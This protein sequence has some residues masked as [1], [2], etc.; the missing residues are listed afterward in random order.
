MN[1]TSNRGNIGLAGL[2]ML[3][4]QA[5]QFDPAYYVTEAM[6]SMDPVP[7]AWVNG[8]LLLPPTFAW[9]SRIANPPPNVPFPAYFNINETQDLA[10]SLTKVVGRHTFKTGYYN[11]YS[12]KANQAA[13]GTTFSSFGA[14]S[15]AQDT[16]GTNPCDT[17]FG[18]AN[19]LT[20]CFNSFAQASKYVV[21]NLVYHN[22]EAYIQDNWKVNQ[23]L[24]L[25]YGVRFVHQTPQYDRLGQGSNFLPDR[26]SASDAPALYEPVCVV[27][28]PAGSACP[29]ASLQARNPR[30]GAVLGPGS[31]I[32]IATLVPGT[33][34]Q[35]NGLFRGGQ[36]IADT[37]YT[38]PALGVAP[39]F[40]MAYDLSG[41][42]TLVLRGGAGLFYDRP[43]GQSA[44]ALPGNPP[45]AESITLR[46][47]NLQSL[48]TGGLS[49]R[50]APAL[51]AIEYE[52]GLPSSWQWNGGFQ[53]TLPWSAAVDFEY[54]GQHSYNTARTVDVNAVDI[55]AAFLSA[56]Q[57][58]TKATSATP[59][60]GAYQTDLLRAYRGY[61]A[62]TTYMFDG[63]RT[64]HSL[65][66]SVTR[67]FAN[68]LAFAFHDTIG[69]VDKQ[70]APARL[71]HDGNGG[72]SFRAD[73]AEADE[74]L[75]NNAPVRHLVRANFVWDLPDLKGTGGAA[76][77]LGLLINDWQLSGVWAAQT[78]AAYTVSY[79]YQS[80][81]GNVNLTGSPDYPARI[82]IIGDQGGGCSSDPYRQF[83]AA[84]FAGPLS[85][86]VGLESGTDYL[87]GCFQSAL[88]LA[89]AR[90][91]RLGGNR[92]LQ[93]RVDIFNAFN[94]A[95]VTNRNT[96]V[97]LAS[98]T[99]PVTAL[100]LPYDSTG[101]VLPNR[102]RPNQAGFGAVT[103]YQ[104]PR[105]VQAQIRFQF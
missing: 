17:S 19:A 66:F 47:T 10:V 100:N 13:T 23:R 69:L 44:V 52:P 39:R 46:Y 56:N 43:L 70:Q 97:S 24:T 14:I 63:W 92:N 21:A 30:T 62:I 90:N 49:T 93:L 38:F 88:D 86:S 78:G 11:T 73:Q 35:T 12:Y 77:P 15:F 42:Q 18:F 8:D 48:G 5:N 85:N 6:N 9:G 83:N 61:G 79:A 41:R 26:W 1:A 55:G 25:D 33:G 50:G 45:M 104:A 28:V 4:P 102:V 101:T 22:R 34:N 65:Q 57:D 36:G 95:R 16:V 40:G 71:Q 29:A 103:A 82:R 94:E 20:G 80:G 84:A 2:P 81:G 76:R 64:Y 7:P 99:D 31:S 68:G 37:T 105:T 89:I 75:G 98:P 3:F 96:S 91:I 54:V 72:L 51:S 27:A 87:R 67:R 74:L 53:M 60:A 58:P 32:A 59:G